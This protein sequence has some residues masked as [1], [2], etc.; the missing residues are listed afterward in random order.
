VGET[1]LQ[2]LKRGWRHIGFWF[3]RGW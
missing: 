2:E 1:H 3:S